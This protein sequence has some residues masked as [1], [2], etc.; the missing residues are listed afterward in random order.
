[1]FKVGLTGN[2]ASGK[3]TVAQIWSEAG[4]PVIRADDLARQV[5][6]P[7]SQGL[8]GILRAFGEDYQRHDGSLD[9]AKLRDRVFGRPEELARLEGILHPLIGSLRDEWLAHHSKVG[10]SMVVAEIPLLYEVGLEKEFDAIVLVTAPVKERLR[11]LMADRGLGEDEASRMMAAQSSQE[12]KVSRAGYVLGNG[13]TRGELEVRSL[14]LLDL[15]RARAR[16][17]EGP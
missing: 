3:S 11:R 1:M 7:G 12:E 9:R 13:G 10:T 16:R 15:L 17:I 2:V 5:V 6:V 4:A 14:A 8:A